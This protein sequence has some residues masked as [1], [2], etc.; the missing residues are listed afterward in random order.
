MATAKRS[1]L[2]GWADSLR[3]SWSFTSTRTPLASGVLLHSV[4]AEEGG[5]GDGGDGGV[6][7]VFD[8]VGDDVGG[9]DLLGGLDLHGVFEVAKVA[10][11]G[12]EGV[13][14]A[15]FG[16]L[17]VAEGGGKAVEDSLDVAGAG[18]GAG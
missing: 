6:F 14:E 8:V 3:F 17:D 18:L 9:A 15:V 2:T 16:E 5:G 11:W 12:V 10:D 7:E 13:G 4:D 1:S